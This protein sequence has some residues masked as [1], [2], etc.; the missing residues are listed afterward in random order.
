MAKCA[1]GNN[2]THLQT[3]LCLRNSIAYN[4]IIN[5]GF[6]KLGNGLHQSLY[7]FDGQIIRTGKP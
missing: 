1:G 2:P 6:F 3:L 5:P 4:H 7:D